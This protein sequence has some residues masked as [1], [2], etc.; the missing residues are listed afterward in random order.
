MAPRGKR[1]SLAAL[2]GDVGDNS[3]V[4]QPPADVGPPRSAPLSE[5]TPNPHNP[6]EDPGENAGRQACR[7]EAR[8]QGRQ[9]KETGTRQ[10]TGQ[11]I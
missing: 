5:L 9:R 11:G 6:R 7:Q 4:D 1:T 3:P 2:A 8:C 10:N